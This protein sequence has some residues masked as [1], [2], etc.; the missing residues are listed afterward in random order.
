M[1][2]LYA[3]DMWVHLVNVQL[4]INIDDDGCKQSGDL[5]KQALAPTK[6]GVGVDLG[7]NMLKRLMQKSQ[8][9]CT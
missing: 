2:Y 1:L 9:V 3:M 8:I 6:A 4:Q 5:E 7:L